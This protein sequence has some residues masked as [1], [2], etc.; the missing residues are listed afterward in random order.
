MEKGEVVLYVEQLKVLYGTLH[1]ARLF[2]QKLSIELVQWGFEVN[3]YDRCVSNKMVGGKHLTV[4]WH[5]NDLKIS[6]ADSKVV[7]LFIEDMESEF[8]KET[9]LSKSRGKVHDYL[10]MILDFTV[11]G[12]L[13]VNMILYIK[14]V[15]YFVPRD[16]MGRAATPA[17]SYLYQ[18]NEVNPVPLAFG[19]E[20]S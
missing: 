3:P 2:W 6:Q 5:A 17:V 13:T 1:A 10:G 20:N 9:P 12:K 8:G 7:D 4:G 18:V 19:Y 15:L 11:K 16:M 14:T